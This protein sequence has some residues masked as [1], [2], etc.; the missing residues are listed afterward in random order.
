MLMEKVLL[1]LCPLLADTPL[2]R[3][4]VLMRLSLLPIS[5]LVLFVMSF[6]AY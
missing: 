5:Q 3:P 1:S 2:S 6:E 4:F